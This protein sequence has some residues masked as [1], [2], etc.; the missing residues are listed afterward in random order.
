MVGL[1]VAIT[2]KGPDGKV[3][4]KDEAISRQEAIRL[5]TL[6]AARLA[7]DEKKKGSI[8]AGKFADLIVLDHDVLNAPAEQLLA[9]KVELTVL[10]GKI[11]YRG[12]H[13]QPQ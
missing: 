8:E 11:V 10:G 1:Y 6:D 12:A 7:W 2:R 9:T 4:G 13:Y 3:F 5:Y